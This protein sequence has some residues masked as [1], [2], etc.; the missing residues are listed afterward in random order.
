M[1][2]LRPPAIEVIDLVKQ[3]KAHRALDG[4]S[5]TVPAGQ[6]CA[7]LGPNGAGKT[8]TIHSLLGLVLPTTGTVRVLGFDV[9]TQR[10][11]ALRRTNFMASYVHFPW[12]MTVREVLRV[13]AELYEVPQAR[14]AIAEAIEVV[15][16][17]HLLG[18]LAQTLSSGE[19]TLLALSK[20]L[21]N[22]PELLFLDEPTASLDVE[23]A[24]EVREVLQRVAAERDM[25]ILITS[26]NMREIERLA[27][28][29]LFLHDGRVLADGTV[30]EL[31]TRFGG[32]DL[33][34]VFLRV[35]KHGRAS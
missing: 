18:R 9:A 21:L 35:A 34:D 19:Q 33:E 17:G 31:R 3:F 25:T 7:L 16:I 5:F 29:V 30:G 4:I 1:P 28:R 23:H 2:A 26:H 11:D 15:G 12:R 22:R 20:S 6:V 27:Q 14:R 32:E 10:S 24:H 13:Y 8:T